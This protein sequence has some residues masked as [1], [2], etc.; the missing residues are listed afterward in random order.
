MILEPTR[1]IAGASK[2]DQHMSRRAI[3]IIAVVVGIVLFAISF[4]ADYI[5][6]GIHPYIYYGW[7]QVTGMVVGIV[8]VVG[9]LITAFFMS[10]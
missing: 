7:K 5:G 1:F 3:G 2:G 9:G 4:L 10:E 6:L 8:L